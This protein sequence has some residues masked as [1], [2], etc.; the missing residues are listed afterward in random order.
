MSEKQQ[1]TAANMRERMLKRYG[2]SHHHKHNKLHISYR[3][4]CRSHPA[5]LLLVDE[6]EKDTNGFP[7]QLRAFKLRKLRKRLDNGRIH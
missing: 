6:Q 7:G 5:P 2:D 3:L 1:H 4:H